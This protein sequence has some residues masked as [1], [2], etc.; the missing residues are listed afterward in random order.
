M[1]AS[2]RPPTA[3]RECM[4]ARAPC[5]ARA[6][7]CVDTRRTGDADL[8]LSVHFRGRELRVR[9]SAASAAPS[10][11]PRGR[12]AEFCLA[13]DRVHEQPA[14]HVLQ[15]CSTARQGR[16]EGGLDKDQTART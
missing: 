7:S 12:L 15:H 1:A 2:W 9:S 10:I 4:R 16:G 14:Y 3:G 5:V 8:P 13:A 11:H 6:I